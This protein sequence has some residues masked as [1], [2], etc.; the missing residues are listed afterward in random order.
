MMMMTMTSFKRKIVA[1][2]ERIAE[3]KVK[4][5]IFNALFFLTVYKLN[6]VEQDNQ[7]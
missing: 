3:I 1:G 4:T 7:I 2:L 5:L 6:Y